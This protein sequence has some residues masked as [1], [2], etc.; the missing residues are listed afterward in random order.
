MLE[1]LQMMWFSMEA[2]KAREYEEEEGEGED[3]FEGLSWCLTF[4]IWF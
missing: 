2:K 3:G 1:I 4:S